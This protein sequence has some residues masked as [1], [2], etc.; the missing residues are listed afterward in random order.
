MKNAEIREK[1]IGRTR[2]LRTLVFELRMIKRILQ[3]VIFVPRHTLLHA[4]TPSSVLV[5]KYQVFFQRSHIHFLS[6]LAGRTFSYIL[7]SNTR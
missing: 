3:V 5:R 6:F 7:Q 2:V 1:K 4:L